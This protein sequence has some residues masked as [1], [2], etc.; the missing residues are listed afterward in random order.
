MLRIIDLLTS[1]CRKIWNILRIKETRI[2]GWGEV[3]W[4]KRVPFTNHILFKLCAECRN[5]RCTWAHQTH[6][7]VHN[8]V[9][10]QYLIATLTWHSY[11]VRGRDCPHFTDGKAKNK[12]ITVNLGAWCSTHWTRFFGADGKVGWGVWFEALLLLTLAGATGA[13]H[14]YKS[15]SR[16]LWGI[17]ETKNRAAVTTSKVGGRDSPHFR[18]EICGRGWRGVQLPGKAHSS[19]CPILFP[20]DL[21]ASVTKGQ[22]ILR[23]RAFYNTDSRFIAWSGPA[24]PSEAQTALWKTNV[25]S[26]N[27]KLECDC[28][29]KLIK[30]FPKI[31]IFSFA[32]SVVLSK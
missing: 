1:E 11:D 2:A 9:T 13:Q 18:K 15:V 3:L 32:T 4:R 30:Q 12:A 20:I 17:P 19:S 25:W 5:I 28:K 16:D 10:A 26:C 6:L 29:H 21:L 27:S 8:A 22:G 23:G 14:G 7:W 31:W 24:E